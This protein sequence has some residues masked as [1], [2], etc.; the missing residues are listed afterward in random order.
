[1][2]TNRFVLNIMN[3]TKNDQDFGISVQVAEGV[4]CPTTDTAV[5]MACIRQA[6]I[7]DIV[8][9]V[10][11]LDLSRGVN[12]DLPWSAVLDGQV[13]FKQKISFVIML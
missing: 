4:N 13:F 11:V 8:V 6:P 5:M 2:P 9:A 12:M 10:K 1:M 7:D 3:E